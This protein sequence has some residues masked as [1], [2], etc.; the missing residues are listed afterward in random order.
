[1]IDILMATYN[2]EKFLDTQISSIINQTVRNWNLIIHDDGSTDSTVSIIRKW[3]AIDSRIRFVDDGISF[4]NIGKNFM[5]L[6][7]FSKSDFICFCDQDDYWF[8]YK[9]ERQL[10][11]IMQFDLHEML[12][13]ITN[14]FLWN[15]DK[16]LI[17]P[18]FD[19]YLAYC[20]EEFLFTNGGLQGC[21]MFFNSCL[22]EKIKEFSKK[23]FLYMHDHLVS[24]IAFTFGKV[25]YLGDLLFL[26]RQHASNS[27][28]HLSKSRKEWLFR[29]IKNKRIPVIS[30][31]AYYGIEA[32][33][34]NYLGEIPCHEEDV[35]KKYL[36]LKDLPPF[37]R[38]F[39]IVFSKFS[40]GHKKHLKLLL[41][42]FIRKFWEENNSV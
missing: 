13:T 29:N 21:A 10:K 16:S 2:G 23:N 15:P 35:L 40:L 25:L 33:F 12:L 24:L 20:L 26:Y 39:S 6:I 27:S 8:E 22:R 28:I 1:M 4:H 9:L 41:K 32:F 5:H 11:F 42:I 14:C 3:C 37:K 19:P 17:V 38:F 7:Q 36:I 34:K 18:K 30:N 31:S